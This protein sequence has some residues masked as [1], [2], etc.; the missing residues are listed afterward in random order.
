M[1]AELEPTPMQQARIIGNGAGDPSP[2]AWLTLK[3]FQ[4]SDHVKQS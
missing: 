2:Y 3:S 4:W 1:L